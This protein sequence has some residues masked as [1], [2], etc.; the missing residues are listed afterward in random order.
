LQ[1]EPGDDP[2]DSFSPGL[3]I[4]EPL[5]LSMKPWPPDKMTM[6]GAAG[7][8]LVD[9]NG[10]QLQGGAWLRTFDLLQPDPRS[11]TVRFGRDSQIRFVEHHPNQPGIAAP[12]GI[13]YPIQ[14]RRL[15]LFG[16]VAPIL[17]PTPTTSLGWGGGIGIRF[18]LGR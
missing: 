12:V 5:S 1:T 4:C 6:G 8:P 18:Y 13:S 14:P 2:A 7:W 17:D 15:E 11:S 9:P 10:I 16:E 3:I